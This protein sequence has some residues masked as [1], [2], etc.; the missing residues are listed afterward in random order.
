[1]RSATTKETDMDRNPLRHRLRRCS[2]PGAI[3]LLTLILGTAGCS[4]DDP[5]GPGVP[6]TFSHSS[7]RTVDGLRLT[8]STPRA[9]FAFGEKI[10]IRVEL[11]N[12]S[13]QPQVLDFLRGTPARYPNLSLNVD[14]GDDLAH[15]IA[16]DGERD[17]FT[18]AA[19]AK[20][21]ATFNWNQVSRL[22]REPVEPGVFR[23]IG[24]VSFDDRETLRVNDLFISL[25]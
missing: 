15:F 22:S 3:L 20:V 6:E 4:D 7:S 11:T 2:L 9:E 24:F 10:T 13:D 14:D 12:V 18:L 17:N 8:V 19:G 21:S 1:L 5:T 25:D 16:G 23:V